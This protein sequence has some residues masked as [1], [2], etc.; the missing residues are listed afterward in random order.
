MGGWDEAWSTRPS[1][2]PR[3][4]TLCVMLLAEDVG[5]DGGGAGRTA[6]RGIHPGCPLQDTQGAGHPVRTLREDT[7]G[8]TPR[9][10]APGEHT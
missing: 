10:R 7:P 6:I 2:L 3:W 1:R 8:R 5:V 4:P 9:G